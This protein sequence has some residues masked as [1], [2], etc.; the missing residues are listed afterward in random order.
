[1]NC[2]VAIKEIE[3]RLNDDSVFVAC[4]ALRALAIL[5]S[6]SSVPRIL[7]R[8]K[9]KYLDDKVKYGELARVDAIEALV[10]LE[11]VECAKEISSCLGDRF[12]SVRH[13]AIRAVLSFDYKHSIPQI[14]GCLD[15]YSEFSINA[16]VVRSSAIKAL[17]AFDSRESIPQILSLLN[18]EAAMVRS[19]AIDA[20]SKM[21]VEDVEARIEELLHDE[22]LIV[23]NSASAALKRLRQI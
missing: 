9:N 4:A 16:D 19:A 7:R 23:R 11:A 6:S 12:A 14:I 1:M 10:E 20:L 15:F 5:N 21:G 2:H 22:A 13:A 17:V 8:L 18:D 3:N